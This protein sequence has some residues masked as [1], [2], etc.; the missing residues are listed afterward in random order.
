MIQTFIAL[1]IVA[2][3]LCVVLWRTVKTLR[4]GGHHCDSCPHCAGCSQSTPTCHTT[5]PHMSKKS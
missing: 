4:G 5:C 2:L 1:T 3:A